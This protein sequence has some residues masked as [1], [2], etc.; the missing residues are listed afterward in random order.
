MPHWMPNRLSKARREMTWPLK[1]CSNQHPEIPWHQT[2]G[3]RNRLIHGYFDVGL[4]RVWDTVTSNLPPLIATLE[5]I[6]PPE[7]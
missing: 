1:E 2:I 4:D 5:K 3:M 6:V 7:N